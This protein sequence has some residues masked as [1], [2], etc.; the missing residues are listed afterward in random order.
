VSVAD[1]LVVLDE[2]KMA[3]AQWG[4]QPIADE[5]LVLRDEPDEVIAEL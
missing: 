3:D 2:S 5:V 4:S 1:V